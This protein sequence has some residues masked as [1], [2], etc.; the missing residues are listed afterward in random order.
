MVLHI[1]I[2]ANTYVYGFL[3]LMLK[4]SASGSVVH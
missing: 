1:K 2:L 3:Q 4:C